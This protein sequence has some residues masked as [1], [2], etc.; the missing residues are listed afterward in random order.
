MRHAVLA[1]AAIAGIALPAAP[2]RAT[3]PPPASLAPANGQVLSWGAVEFDGVPLVVQA[4]EALGLVEVEVARDPALT[5]TVDEIWLD[6]T[7]PG[8]YEGTF[9][10]YDED[11]DPGTYYWR[12][13]YEAWD[14]DSYEYRTVSGEVRSFE[15]RP[16]Y[17]APRVDVRLRST[18]LA[19]KR[20]AAVLT[21]RPGSEPAADRLSLLETRGACPRRPSAG[22]GPRLVDAAE[23][24]ASGT[25]LIPLRPHRLGRLRLCGYV[26]VGAAVIRRDSESADVVNPPVSRRR[27]LRW[28]LT[29]RGMGQLRVG[30]TFA[31][32]E[33]ATGRAMNWEYGDYRGCEYWDLRGAPRG[34]ALMMA[35]GRLARVDVFRRAWRTA[36]GI[37]IGDTAGKVRRR[38]GVVRSRPHPYDPGGRYLIVGRGGR[39]MIFETNRRG[40]VTSFRGGRSREVGYIEGCL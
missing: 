40:R 1:A 13:S 20:Y 18:L 12:A 29:L 34:M 36:R 24:P 25:L 28:G 33:R 7:D 22:T 19:G 5:S 23:P 32:I 21:Y 6:E 16:P 4:P 35:Y 31:Q 17:R 39:R 37:R 8:R 9:D 26:T 14:P 11:T 3:D 2:A 30:M 10:L 38:Y 15:V 27:M